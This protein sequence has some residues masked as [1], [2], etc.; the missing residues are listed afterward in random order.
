MTGPAISKG[1]SKRNSN[2]AKNGVVPVNHATPPS[3]WKNKQ[4]RV[5][6]IE[7]MRFSK[8]SFERRFWGSTV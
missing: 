4:V 6:M 2:T 5:L 7:I 3:D 1:V 8:Q